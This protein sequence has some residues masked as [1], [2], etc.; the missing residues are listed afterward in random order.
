[1]QFLTSVSGQ[2]RTHHPS[3]STG[4][5]NA[6]CLKMPPSRPHPDLPRTD[7]THNHRH[8]HN[9]RTYHSLSADPCF[10]ICFVL[11]EARS[12]EK[13]CAFCVIGNSKVFPLHEKSPL[14]TYHLQRASYTR[15]HLNSIRDF[16]L[17]VFSLHTSRLYPNPLDSIT[18]TPGI[19]YPPLSFTAFLS[20]S[21]TR[22][23]R[24]PAPKL[25]STSVSRNRLSTCAVL[26][27]RASMCTPLLH[28]LSFFSSLL[29]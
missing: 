13:E 2:S 9:C 27:V 25:P 15:Y 1:M 7:N 19:S 29:S 26:S 17:P 18:G 24:N 4:R 23:F 22:F 3:G 21:R 16:R 10:F 12:Y 28:C 14:Q 6:G 5:Q 11:S 8:R 20:H